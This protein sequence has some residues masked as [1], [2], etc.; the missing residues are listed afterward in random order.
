MANNSTIE[1]EYYYEM[2][3][4]DE[5]Y[6]SGEQELIFKSS[7]QLIFV[8][9]YSIIGFVG[10]F[11]NTFIIIII[12]SKQEMWNSTNVFICNMA[13]SDIVISLTAIPLTPLTA[14][15]GDWYFGK[16]ACVL[17]PAF[18]G[19]SVYISSLSLAAIA[20]DRYFA[21]NKSSPA[22]KNPMNAWC[23]V[24]L[25][26]IIS[27]ALVSPYSCNMELREMKDSRVCMENWSG[28][29]RYVFG[30]A[31]I[32]V[33]LVLPVV[34]SAVAYRKILVLLQKHSSTLKQNMSKTSHKI[35]QERQRNKRRTHI[36][37][38]ILVL[39]V[40][41]WLPLN[42]INL[43][44][45]VG[46][47]LSCWRYY[48]FLFFCFHILA[49]FSVCINPI[50]Y[51]WLNASIREEIE[52]RL[53]R[54]KS[55]FCAREEHSQSLELNLVIEGRITPSMRIRAINAEQNNLNHV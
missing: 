25:I 33:Q 23:V 15:T 1:Y 38:A 28:K 53:N 51:G 42:L 50:L 49:S 24:L 35:Q 36:L 16:I 7:V 3:G 40:I 20:V 46:V 37:I 9:I 11:S 31:T 43:L 21:M 22:Q 41:C 18:Q 30:V 29:F 14:F 26:D 48:F 13:V 55:V 39:F 12:L 10:I 8:I 45:D 32:L 17:L 34:I 52:D 4:T 54:L 19:G 44:E 47:R 2:N 27:M 5:E 6:C